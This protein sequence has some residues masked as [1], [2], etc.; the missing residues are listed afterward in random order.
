MLNNK[1]KNFYWR[2]LSIQSFNW[3]SH[4]YKR[5]RLILRSKQFIVQVFLYRVKVFFSK[6]IAFTLNLNFSIDLMVLISEGNLLKSFT[7]MR[8]W[9]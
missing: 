9:S 3:F 7:L 8:Q 5:L 4:V 1:N 2:P 6:R